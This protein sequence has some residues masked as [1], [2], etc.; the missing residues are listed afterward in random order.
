MI[1]DKR[2]RTPEEIENC[3]R[4]FRPLIDR[5]GKPMP[6]LTDSELKDSE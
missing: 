4:W 5:I 2:P 3:R 6:K 1:V